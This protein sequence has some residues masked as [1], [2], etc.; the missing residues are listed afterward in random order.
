LPK[1]L[2]KKKGGPGYHLLLQQYE[3]QKLQKEDCRYGEQ[4]E[5]RRK[6]KS[7][8]LEYFEE[9]KTEWGTQE[10]ARRSAG[11]KSQGEFNRGYIVV[12]RKWTQEKG[13]KKKKASIAAVR[14]RGGSVPTKALVERHA[15]DKETSRGGGEREMHGKE[16]DGPEKCET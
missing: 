3:S 5:G 14:T 15:D 4:G 7:C 1:G 9:G 10:G 2:K 16:G 13:A 8:F 6:E 11:K 12:E